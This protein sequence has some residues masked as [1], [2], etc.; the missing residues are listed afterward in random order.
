MPR[1]FHSGH[2]YR[3]LPRGIDFNC[4]VEQLEGSEARMKLGE[5]KLGARCGM[6]GE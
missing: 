3:F 6:K 1:L 2:P 5:F 4:V